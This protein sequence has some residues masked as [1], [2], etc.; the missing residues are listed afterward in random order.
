MDVKP[1]VWQD[2][3]INQSS[4]VAGSSF[5]AGEERVIHPPLEWEGA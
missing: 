5:L 4:N 1:S 2:I 3:E